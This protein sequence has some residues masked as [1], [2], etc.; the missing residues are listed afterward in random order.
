MVLKSMESGC[1][2]IGT[3]SPFTRR[4]LPAPLTSGRG[5]RGPAKGYSQANFTANT[6]AI[7]KTPVGHSLPRPASTLLTT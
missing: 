3:S 4:P 2:D 7:T 6:A 1:F 5:R